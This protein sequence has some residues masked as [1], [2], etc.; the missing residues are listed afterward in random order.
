MHTGILNTANGLVDKASDLV[1]ESV[2]RPAAKLGVGIAGGVI[3]FWLLQK[4]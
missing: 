4:V 3:V 2:P 1:P